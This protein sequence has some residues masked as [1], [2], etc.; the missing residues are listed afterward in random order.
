MSTAS[1]QT[2]AL[3][4]TQAT[5][6][7][8]AIPPILQAELAAMPPV[9]LTWHPAP[10]EWS[11]QQVIGHLIECEQRGFAG[12]IRLI[13]ADDRPQLQ[14]WD[15]DSVALARRDDERAA[16]DL[17]REFSDMRAASTAMVAS[18][19]AAD[20][21]RGGN[22][23]NVGFLT[24]RDVL[25]EWVGHDRIHLAQIGAN[26]RAYTWPHMGNGQRFVLGG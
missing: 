10:G 24:V 19:T 7:L 11:A 20:Y 4:P 25:H 23:P 1:A 18:L 9:L 14:E 17:L 5:A 12:R 13:L 15:P 16:A 8:A 3:T 26:I 2:A 22:H 21:A 6:L